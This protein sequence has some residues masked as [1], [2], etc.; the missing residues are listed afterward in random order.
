MLSSLDL[1]GILFTLVA[2]LV[3]WA[4][5]WVGIYIYVG[6]VQR[7][8]QLRV[9]SGEVIWGAVSRMNPNR[10]VKGWSG[11]MVY[12]S[13]NELVFEPAKSETRRGAPRLAWQEPKIQWS[14]L[15][16]DRVMGL[17]FR[18]ITVDGLEQ[19]SMHN[20]VGRFPAGLPQ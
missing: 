9:D 19:F 4:V 12:T 18:V 3:I 10:P 13:T 11:V 2:F 1:V 6:R 14:P 17:K 7:R 16:R 15:R 20:P 5:T 8:L